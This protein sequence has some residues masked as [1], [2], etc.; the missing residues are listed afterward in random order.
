M[1]EPVQDLGDRF[2]HFPRR[3]ERPA[4]HH[5]GQCEIPRRFDLGQG[6]FSSGIPGG[7]NVGTEGLKHGPIA[8]IVE[9]P[10]R[11]DHL[12]VGKRQWVGL[13]IDQPDQVTMLLVRGERLQM[14]PANAKEHAACLRSQ[15]LRRCGDIIDLDPAVARRALPG[16]TLQRQQRHCGAFASRNR[17]RTY[18]SCEWMRGIDDAVD[19]LGTNVVHEAGN[20]AKAADTPGNRRRQRIFRAAGIG[21]HRIDMRTVRQSRRKPVRVG[22]TAQDQNAQSSRW[23]G[24][25]DREQ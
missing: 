21:Q 4:D 14:L 17:I 13:R 19:I 24:C 5:H 25:H 15:S 22:S 23:R 6:G 2:D 18:L 7:D 16:R 11:H 12:G 20:A 1:T 10:A 9:R 8:G 3:Y